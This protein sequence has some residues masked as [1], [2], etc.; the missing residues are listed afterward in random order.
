[1]KVSWLMLLAAE[2]SNGTPSSGSTPTSAAAWSCDEDAEKWGYSKN[3]GTD[4]P[5]PDG[6]NRHDWKSAAEKARVFENS[7]WLV[8]Q[9]EANGVMMGQI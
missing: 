4:H 1:M 7:E 6:R 8:F 3:K 5:A 9:P 2:N